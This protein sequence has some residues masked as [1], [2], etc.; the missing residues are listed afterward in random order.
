LLEADD[1][2][3]ERGVT[4]LNRSAVSIMGNCLKHNTDEAKNMEEL[5]SFLRHF[6]AEAER[7]LSLLELGCVNANTN[8]SG[9]EDRGQGNKAHV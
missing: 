6:K 7:W 9:L 4:F 2:A 5:K 8:S 3:E 1:H